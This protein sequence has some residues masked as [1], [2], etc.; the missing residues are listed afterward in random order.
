MAGA[1]RALQVRQIQERTENREPCAWQLVL[2]HAMPDSSPGARTGS[3]PR[4]LHPQ[5]S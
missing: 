3:L 4:P 1:G 2:W 5:V